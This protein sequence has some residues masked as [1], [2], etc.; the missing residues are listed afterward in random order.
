MTPNSL[1]CS[2][3][4]TALPETLF[5]TGQVESCPKCRSKLQ[6]V[7]FPAFRTGI[8]IGRPGET[9]VDTSEASC[10]FH[11]GKRAAVACDS[12]GRFLC[13][14]CDLEVGGRHVCPN[15]FSSGRKKGGM[16]NLDVYRRSWPGIGLLLTIAPMFGSFLVPFIMPFT[17]TAA[18]VAFGIGLRKPGSITG[19]RRILSYIIGVTFAV[20]QLAAIAWWGKE[21]FRAFNP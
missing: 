2:K 12:C 8:Q 9:L 14:L 13:S 6:L 15:C 7:V 19:R 3:C 20:A 17:A 16:T 4:R 11:A 18:L 5:N 10:F 1:L 21:I